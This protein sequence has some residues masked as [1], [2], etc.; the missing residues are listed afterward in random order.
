MTKDS[1]MEPGCTEKQ[2]DGRHLKQDGGRPA[3][4]CAFFIDKAGQVGL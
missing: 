2:A 3:A 1:F 4:F